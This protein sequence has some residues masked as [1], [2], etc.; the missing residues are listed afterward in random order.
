MATQILIDSSELGDVEDAVGQARAGRC[1]QA[2]I[3]PRVE[4][5]LLEP[6]ACPP[7]G[8]YS[9]ISQ[10]MWAKDGWLLFTTGGTTAAPRPFRM[11]RFDRDQAAWLFARELWAMG[12]RPGDVG[13]FT[14]L[15]S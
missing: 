1:D 9:P 8:D 15:A 3:D 13:S 7:W 10:V 12:V 5:D 6:P 2:A 11:T 4:Q 14:A